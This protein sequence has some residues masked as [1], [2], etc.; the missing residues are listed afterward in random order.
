MGPMGIK[1]QRFKK[2]AESF[3]TQCVCVFHLYRDTEM[4]A[5]KSDIDAYVRGLSHSFHLPPFPL[6]HHISVN[7]TN[8]V[9]K[10]GTALH[11]SLYC[12]FCVF[13]V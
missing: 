4:V 12:S 2:Y 7:W 10:A 9:L 1:K 13:C 6:S 3:T 11:L 5:T 8:Q